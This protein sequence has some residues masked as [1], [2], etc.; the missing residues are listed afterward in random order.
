[1]P[2]FSYRARK[3]SGEVVQGILDVN[4]RTAALAQIERLGLFPVAVEQAKGQA[5]PKVERSKD[6]PATSNILP[7]T[8]RALFN[9]KRRPSMQ[10]LATFT[11][12]L[13]NLD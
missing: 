5:A 3:R 11:T 2:Q 8:L 7:P 4:D 12:Q 9:R 10:E 6:R 13:A 1:M